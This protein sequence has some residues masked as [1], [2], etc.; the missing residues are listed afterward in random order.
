MTSLPKN[1][2]QETVEGFGREWTTF[3][4]SE[5]DFAD[6]DRRAMFDNYF[7]IFP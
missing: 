7:S 5:S 3:T 1:T 4:Q 6:E 2:D